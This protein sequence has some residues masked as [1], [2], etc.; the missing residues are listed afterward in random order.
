[1]QDDYLRKSEWILG[2]L[3]MIEILD[4]CIPTLFPSIVINTILCIGIIGFILCRIENVNN[5]LKN[6]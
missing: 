1:M 3:I 5:L 2:G 4:V 6:K